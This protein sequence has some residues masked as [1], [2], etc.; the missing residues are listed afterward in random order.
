MNERIL[1]SELAKNGMTQKD[2]AKALKITEST[3][4]RKIKGL[5]CLNSNE[6]NTMINIFNI[7]ITQEYKNLFF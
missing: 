6:I 7:P 4:I 2:L 1:R 3:M 5:S